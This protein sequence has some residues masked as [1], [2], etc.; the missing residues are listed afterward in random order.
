LSH[1]A[2]QT[3]RLRSTNGLLQKYSQSAQYT[4]CSNTFTSMVI[5]HDMPSILD[6]LV[7]LC[8]YYI[9]TQYYNRRR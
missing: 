2:Q 7:V 8:T 5:Q 1:I 3:Q 9:N 4:T 6:E